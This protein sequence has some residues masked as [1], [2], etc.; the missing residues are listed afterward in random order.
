MTHN[1]KK[2]GEKD[3]KTNANKSQNLLNRLLK[4]GIRPH[5]D[6]IAPIIADGDVAVVAFEPMKTGKKALRALG[7]NGR[8]PV[9]RLGHHHAKRMAQNLI[10]QGDI[11]GGEWLARRRDG[12]IFVFVQGGTLMFNLEPGGGFGPEPGTLDREWLS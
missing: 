3:M 7:W 1:H 9:F 12:R 4:E 8:D 5:A 6:S 2:R 10:S 11:A